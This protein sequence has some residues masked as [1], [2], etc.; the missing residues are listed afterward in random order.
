MKLIES[1]RNPV[2]RPRAII[3]TAVVLMVILL[4]LLVA[5]AV[6]STY[7]FCASFCHS[8]QRD[9]IASFNNSTHKNVACITCHE[10][11]G[12]DPITFL[13]LKA[14]AGIGEV[15]LMLSSPKNFEIPLNRNSHLAMGGGHMTSKQCTQCHDLTTQKITPPLGLKIDHDVHESQYIACTVCHNRV[16]HNE[17]GIALVNTDPKTGAPNRGHVNFMTMTACAR[18]HRLA[19]DGQAEPSPFSSAKG[20]C[21]TCHTANFDLKPKNHNSPNFMANHGKLAVAQDEKVKEAQAELA[22]E[23]ERKVNSDKYA[24]AVKDVPLARTIN[25]CYTCHEKKFCADCHGGVEMPHPGNFR[26]SHKKE[27]QAYPAACAKCHNV[28]ADGANSCSSCHHSS[29]NV[30]DYKFST[31]AA[32]LADHGKTAQVNGPASC[33]S[34]HNPTDCAKCHASGGF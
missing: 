26:A 10:P 7:W 14:E 32:W 18:C 22:K 31:A 30:A 16:A 6:S 34:C 27:A 12:A 24:Q 3:W 1:F 4:F 29:P 17:D 8:A 2:T 5:V 9:T 33:F 19:D 25:E 28:N 23:P 21:K 20:A 15:P 11:V 13:Y